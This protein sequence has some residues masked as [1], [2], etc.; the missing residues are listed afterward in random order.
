[1]SRPSREQHDL[2]G[3]QDG[4]RP[5]TSSDIVYHDSQ[6]HAD[7]RAYMRLETQEC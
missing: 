6:R 4:R 3:I 5:T 1:M 2:T 7:P